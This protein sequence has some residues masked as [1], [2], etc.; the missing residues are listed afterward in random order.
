MPDSAPLDSDKPTTIV[1]YQ[2]GWAQDNKVL[3]NPNNAK[4]FHL[5]VSPSSSIRGQKS[6]K[7]STEM[8]ILIGELGL[9]HSI[10]PSRSTAYDTAISVFVHWLMPSWGLVM[11]SV[12]VVARSPLGALDDTCA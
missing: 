9:P 12:L 5:V 7:H 6:C 3:N 11:R 8:C 1:T 2:N 4:T 10:N